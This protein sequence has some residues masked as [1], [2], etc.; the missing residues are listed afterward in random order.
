MTKTVATLRGVVRVAAAMTAFGILGFPIAASA[1]FIDGEMTFSGDIEP[2][3]GTDLS[4]ATGLLFPSFDFGVDGTTGDFAAI[5]PGDIGA[6]S[7]FNFSPLLP[8]PVDPLLS[9]GGFSYVLE[10]V[11]V[12]DQD[13]MEL[14][15]TGT[16]T[17][18]AAG[19]D[20]TPYDFNMSVNMVTGELSN[21]S[22]SI[23]PAAVIPVP[24]AVL[25]FGSAL[26]GLGLMRRRPA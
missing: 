2:T 13:A 21:F 9:I 1:A 8:N 18:S 17:L 20:D 12:V 10:S 24:G 5:Q 11:A 4:D 25:L 26:A 16:G 19:F 15:I 14:L 3:G 6:I 22:A 23:G 7:N